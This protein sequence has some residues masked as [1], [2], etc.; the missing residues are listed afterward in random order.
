MLFGRKKTHDVYVNLYEKK[1]DKIYCLGEELKDNLYEN[2]KLVHSFM[3][4]LSEK[5][6]NFIFLFVNNPPVNSE[7]VNFKKF[8]SHSTAILSLIYNYA[9]RYNFEL[10]IRFE[11]LNKALSFSPNK[12]SYDS[13]NFDNFIQTNLF[14]NHLNSTPFD[15]VYIYR[16]EA[17]LLFEEESDIFKAAE[18]F[19][20][21]HK[22]K[23]IL[24][25]FNILDN[26][27]KFPFIEQKKLQS[28]INFLV[29]AFVIF[30]Y[31]NGIY[32]GTY[33]I[34]DNGFYEELI[35]ASYTEK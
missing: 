14:T 3:D 12:N 21:R 6:I 7:D 24:M 35:N 23:C 16:Y 27:N 11:G 32:F 20:K 1:N 2:D 25:H 33:H 8:I 13:K 31:L 10:R 15:D 30:C 28:K 9:Y 18:E 29:S 4:E 17:N 5:E 22:N 26:V 19:S 34:N